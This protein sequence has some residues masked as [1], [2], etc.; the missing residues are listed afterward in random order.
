MHR[1]RA[2]LMRPASGRGSACGIGRK[3]THGFFVQTPDGKVDANK[4]TSEGVFVFSRTDP[5]AD[6]V[7]G[8]EITVTGIVEEFRRDNEPFALTLT[9]ISMRKDRDELR[10]VSK[11]N[12]LP[13]PIVLTP[14]D[15]MSNTVDNLEKYEGMRVQIDELTVVAPTG[16]RIDSKTGASVSDGAFFGVLKPV[17]RPFREPGFD[18]RELSDLGGRDQFKKD[19]RKHWS[20]MPTRK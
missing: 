1:C 2:N 18:V 7:V 17:P 5:P 12:P 8:N 19:I 15:F 16:G 14:T 6:A 13:K 9:E 11:S 20:S 10:V 3:G 4:N